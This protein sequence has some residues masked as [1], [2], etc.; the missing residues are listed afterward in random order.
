MSAD[1]RPNAKDTFDNLK[2]P[3]PFFQKLGLIIRNL[4]L[5]MTR[6]KNCCGHPGDPGC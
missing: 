5:K 2:K 3:M 1:N 6:M 4:F